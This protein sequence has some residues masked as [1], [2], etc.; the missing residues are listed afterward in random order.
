MDS[1]ERT[2]LA[3]DFQEPDRVPVDVWMSGGFER[4]LTRAL[5]VSREEFLDAHDVDLR[6]IEGPAYTGPPLEGGER[7]AVDIW[8]VRREPVTLEVGGAVET[9]REVVAP[10]LGGARTV[11]DV[12]RYE[13]WPS[14]DWFDYTGIEAQCERVREQGRVAVFMG[15]RL[16]RKFIRTHM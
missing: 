11:E 2:F 5:G 8:G 16:N 6:Y 13:H 9:Y 15:D 3:L 10:P 14:A 12:E 1:R 7:G 4:T